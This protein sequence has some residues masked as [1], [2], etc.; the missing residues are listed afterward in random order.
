MHPL[1]Q[2]L[3]PAA[4]LQPSFTG[5]LSVLP[6]LNDTEFDAPM[7]MRSP[8]RGFRPYYEVCLVPE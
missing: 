1:P 5:A 7:A 3:G 2:P 4:D 8:V 6:A